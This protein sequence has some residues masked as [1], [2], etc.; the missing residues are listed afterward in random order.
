MVTREI[1]LLVVEC[2][3]ENSQFCLKYIQVY[4]TQLLYNNFCGIFVCDF[5]GQ[6][7][8]L[9]IL[10]VVSVLGRVGYK[11]FITLNNGEVRNFI[12]LTLIFIK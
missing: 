12:F 9:H 1:Q 11:Y 5:L 6:K 3:F 2:L 4:K 7:L 10:N 8:I